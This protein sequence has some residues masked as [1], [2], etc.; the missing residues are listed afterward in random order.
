[1]RFELTTP[2]LARLCSTPE[3]RPLN[4]DAVDFADRAANDKYPSWA[5][6]V[7][8]GLHPRFLPTAPTASTRIDEK[9]NFLNISV[10]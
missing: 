9:V 5:R 4:F 6:G 10:T 2:T 7:T 8:I 3:L 1:M